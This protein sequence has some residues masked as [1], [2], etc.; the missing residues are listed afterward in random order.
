MPVS[1]YIRPFPRR[2]GIGTHTKRANARYET[3]HRPAN[4]HVGVPTRR[5]SVPVSDAAGKKTNCY[6]GYPPGNA[7]DV[8]RYQS[9]RSHPLRGRFRDAISGLPIPSP[10][11]TRSGIALCTNKIRD[12]IRPSR[13]RSVMSSRRLFASF[14]P[15]RRRGYPS[16]ASQACEARFRRCAIPCGCVVTGSLDGGTSTPDD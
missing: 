5:G 1:P 2:Y 10:A 11:S 4:L 7:Q 8:G 12:R 16:S 3:R 15:R 13:L 14:G 6:G 9:F